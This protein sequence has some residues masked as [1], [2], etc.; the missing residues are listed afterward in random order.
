MPMKGYKMRPHQ[1]IRV[2]IV[3]DDYLVSEMIRGLLDELG[4]RVV[5]EAENGHEAIELN[6]TLQP[7]V[8]LMDLEMPGMGGL[9]A[10]NQITVNQPTPIVVLTA[11]ETPD[12]IDEASQAGVGAYLVKP[13][14]GQEIE[15]A[16]TIALA[17]FEDLR[18][19]H[20]LNRRLQSY[21]EELNA[22]A[23]TVAHD[24]QSQL[25]LITGFADLL[26]SSEAELPVEVIQECVE[27][28]ASNA[29]KMS[30][31]IDE[32]L[33]LASVRQQEVKLTPLDMQVIVHESLQRLRFTQAEYDGEIIAPSTWPAVMGYGPWVEEV[34]F[35]YMSNAL[36]YG[37]TPP[38]VILGASPADKGC[39]RF[40][41][42]DNGNGLSKVDQNRLFT[43]FT[44]LDQVRTKGHGLGLSIVWRIIEKL[45]GNVGVE[46]S[47]GEGSTFW[48][49]L[50]GV[51]E[52]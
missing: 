5:G 10:A 43:P 35:N 26:L 39:V 3:E 4:Y 36:K 23:H 25:G 32:L 48:F 8:I 15:R 29:Y 46:S 42:R 2:L 44:Q 9:T 30:N 7:D 20:N 37:G 50:P 41:V 28:I 6:Q 51:K 13:P 17:R 18:Q 31:I 34:W 40:W 12:L 52:E 45:G 47:P 11:Y 19:L 1:E 24:L 33:L 16:I 27:S 14:N 21:N 38:Q 49:T 22:F